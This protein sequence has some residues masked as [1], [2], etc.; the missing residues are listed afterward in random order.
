MADIPEGSLQGILD[1]G[2]GDD[3]RSRRPGSHDGDR[4]GDDNGDED[5]HDDDGDPDPANSSSERT[6][7]KRRRSRKGLDKK[8][9][10]PAEG[11]GK[12]Y[13]RAEHL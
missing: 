2:K 6:A 7:R 5:D 13:S 8:F 12:R 4:D 9:E 11:C 3:P 10:C 1:Q